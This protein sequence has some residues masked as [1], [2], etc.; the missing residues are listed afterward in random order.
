MIWFL[1]SYLINLRAYPD[2]IGSD[3][4][5]IRWEKPES[6]DYEVD[7]IK[8]K[9]SH[10]TYVT[11][12]SGWS[13]RLYSPFPDSFLHKAS[14]Y[15]GFYYHYT[16][17]IFTGNE[18]I[19][20]TCKCVSPTPPW[21]LSYY[22]PTGTVVSDTFIS[23]VFKYSRMSFPEEG[24]R[25]FSYHKGDTFHYQVKLGKYEIEYT[26]GRL[27]TTHHFYF[28]TIPLFR[29]MDTVV[30]RLISDSIRSV[31]GNW[32]LDGNQNEIKEGSPDDD[33][34]I[35]CYASLKGD[36]N[37]DGAV[38]IEDFAIFA[39]LWKK[40]RMP[41]K[42]LAPFTGTIPYISVYPDSIIDF[43]DFCA[44]V[45]LWRWSLQNGRRG[46]DGNV[47]EDFYFM[48]GRV[49]ADIEGVRGIEVITDGELEWEIDGLNMKGEMEGKRVY[50][51]AFT[52]PRNL[53]GSVFV[54]KDASFTEIKYVDAGFHSHRSLLSSSAVTLSG[55]RVP[56]PYHEGEILLFG[57]DGRKRKTL[58]IVDGYVNLN[59]PP[60]IYILKGKGFS[61]KIAVI[62]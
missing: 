58:K 21:T 50:A 18:T 36:Y 55:G 1:F 34:V 26:P 19:L 60:G 56:V 51:I 17:F 39:S 11:D 23:A 15:N 13:P 44:F 31:R 52:A 16:F 9:S 8:I 27:D 57:M 35:K 30:I 6:M 20:D 25:V 14:F 5:L 61:A 48:K 42:E 62:K 10:I 47:T 29:S 7:S 3:Y 49:Y 28:Y 37:L 33:I 38:D 53:H 24:V 41:F 22:P 59:V 12:P 46:K 4:I 43:D 32:P 2:T 45:L 40:E 54:L